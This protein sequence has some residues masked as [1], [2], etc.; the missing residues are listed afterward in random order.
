MEC[1]VNR[2]GYNELRDFFRYIPQD[3]C[4]SE[5]IENMFISQSHIT[6]TF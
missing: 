3:A 1:D 6:K 4:P 5:G 2:K